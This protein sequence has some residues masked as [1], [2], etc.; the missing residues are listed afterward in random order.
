MSTGM[1]PFPWPDLEAPADTAL[2]TEWIARMRP[3]VREALCNDLNRAAHARLRA[4]KG[5]SPLD[6]LHPTR[7]SLPLPADRMQGGK[8]L[9]ALCHLV[10][11]AMEVLEAPSRAFSDTGR[12]TLLMVIFCR[13]SWL[14]ALLIKAYGEDCSLLVWDAVLD[15]LLPP[16]AGEAKS[17]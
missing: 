5:P 4:R 9:A 8:A 16:D 6:W 17:A 3:E 10:E 1:F 15:A 7:P 2:Q 13:L 11:W 12:H 14:D